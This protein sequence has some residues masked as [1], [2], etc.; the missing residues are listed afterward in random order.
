MVSRPRHHRAGPPRA[1]RAVRRRA[2]ARRRSRQIAQDGTVD[3]PADR[4]TLRLPHGSGVRRSGTALLPQEGGAR[5][6]VPMHSSV[7]VP[8]PEAFRHNCTL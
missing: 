6:L 5:R 2:A 1:G 4:F 3:W 8:N 7:G